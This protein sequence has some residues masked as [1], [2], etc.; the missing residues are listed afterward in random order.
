MYQATDHC[1]LSQQDLARNEI[2]MA[3]FAYI[4]LKHI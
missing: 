2:H 4:N 3:N 1:L